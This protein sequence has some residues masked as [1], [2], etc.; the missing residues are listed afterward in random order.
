MILPNMILQRHIARRSRTTSTI[1]G[2]KPLSQEFADHA[3]AV[4]ELIDL[5]TCGLESGQPDV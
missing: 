1:F 4:G 5:A 2:S 3:L